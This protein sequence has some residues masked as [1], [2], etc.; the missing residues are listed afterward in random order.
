MPHR[1]RAT[2]SSLTIEKPAAGGRM[3]ARADGQVVLRRRR[4]S[5]RT[6]DRADRARRQGRRVRDTA[7]RSRSR[8]PIGA[9]P[10]PIR[11]AAAACTRTSTYPRQL[12]IKAQVIADAF[13]RI[14]RLESACGVR[15][16]ASPEDGYR[17]RARLHVRGGRVGFFREGTHE[18]CDAARTRQLLPAKLRSPLERLVALGVPT[19]QRSRAGDLELSENVAAHRAR[20]D[21]G[22]PRPHRR[23]A[24]P[25][26]RDD[27]PAIDGHEIAWRRH[28]LAFFQGNRYLLGS[29]VT[30]VV[31]QIDRAARVVDLYA[32]AGLFALAGGVG[33]GARVTAVEGDRMAAADLGV[34]RT[35][36][37]RASVEALHQ[38]VETF[39]VSARTGP[40]S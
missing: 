19:H 26:V 14:A 10:A 1:P 36:G 22:G 8:R 13:T 39:R 38:S 7:P 11:S 3:I 24:K 27:A 12:A 20:R 25:Y 15:V 32:G 17:M 9:I 31:A 18:L 6:G 5:R 29:L 16:A 37:R 4:D 28:V 40:T 33:R 2:P 21:G 34:E 30:H 35:A 23:P